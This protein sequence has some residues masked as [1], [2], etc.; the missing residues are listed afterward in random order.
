M[1]ALD[2]IGSRLQQ[3]L[4][5][6]FRRREAD[7]PPPPGDW[8]TAPDL[9]PPALDANRSERQDSPPQLQP[10][11][12]VFGYTADRLER[13]DLSGSGNGAGRAN[14]VEDAVRR[15]VEGLNS[16]GDQVAIAL[17]AGGN[18]LVPWRG[19][20]VGG[21][22]QYGYDIT[23]AQRGDA[24][25]PGADDDQTRYEVTFGKNLMGGVMAAM[26]EAPVR[27]GYEVNLRSADQVTMTFQTREE[28]V[29]AVTILQHV[30]AAETARDAGRAATPGPSLD[31]PA[32][33][34]LPENGSGSLPAGLPNPAEPAARM[35]EPSRADLEFLTSHITGFTTRL[36][37]QDRAKV[38]AELGNLGLEQRFD[39][40][41]QITR[42]VTLPQG[43]E[44]GRVTYTV[45]GELAPSTREKLKTG[46]G[47]WSVQNIVENGRVRAEVSI[48]YPIDV[49]QLGSTSPSG[50]PVP[51]TELIS[52][53]R[54]GRPDEIA[55]KITAERMDQPVIDLSRTDFRRLELNATLADPRDNARPVLDRIFDGNL[56]GAVA[57]SNG[58]LMITR[59][60]EDVARSG[61]NQQHELGFSEKGL[62]ASVS[63]IA[64]IG[65]DDV[66]NRQRVELRPEQ[67]P[68]ERPAPGGSA[69]EQLVVVPR[70]GLNV[71]EAPSAEAE[72]K[73]VLYHGTFVEATGGRETDAHGREWVEVKGRGTDGGEVQGWVAAEHVRTHAEGAMGPA[74]RV[75]PKLEE[76]GYRAVTVRPGD[77]VWQIAR[78]GG[79]DFGATMR[80]NQDHLIDQSLVFAGDKVYLPGTG[81]PPA[82]PEPPRDTAPPGGGP[83]NPSGGS[84]STPEAGSGTAPVPSPGPSTA[85]PNGSGSG[86]GNG[87]SAPSPSPGPAPSRPTPSDPPT[88]HGR[89]SLQEVLRE[90]Q[91]K[92]D[93][94]IVEVWRPDIQL[95]PVDLPDFVEGPIRGAAEEILDKDLKL[96]NVPRSEAEILDRL[97]TLELRDMLSIKDQAFARANEHYPWEGRETQFYGQN[98]GH[99]DA[100]RHAYWNALMTRR[101]GEGFAT[102][103]ATA[104]EAG[105]N[106]PGPREAMDL[107]NNELGRRIA[108]ENP[109]ASDAELQQLI[110]DAVERGEAVVIDAN[111]HL[112]WSHQ[113]AFLEHGTA[114]GQAPQPGVIDPNTSGS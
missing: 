106:N 23:V 109:E 38:S 98:D 3:G 75:N 6:V 60:T 97:D 47:P 16:D 32:A 37:P 92:D 63:L 104:H 77:N 61:V 94:E 31:N 1:N 100:F 85:P 18:V 70:D 13:G 44:P 84:P 114:D 105:Q 33:N 66:S 9:R 55:V 90:Y 87:P 71:R 57:E 102:E 26:P 17:T 28:A 103:Y 51:E 21:K 41:R 65:T 79:V 24:R 93:E 96:E 72:K 108:V 95:G 29:R 82:E 25:T 11:T 86:S 8:Q 52:G 30:A 58:A 14:P 48:S 80:L 59:T 22:V 91:V 20:P 62:E 5:Q 15:G 69:G 83:S 112:A 27:A 111:G 99:N 56:R 107:Y 39:A 110:K 34:P 73:G 68:V 81:K 10:A 46:I 64:N 40:N 78:D 42:T 74:G 54:L 101:F 113:V 7:P 89:P 67:E 50:K 12:A 43:D 53:A 4:E 35:L 76:Q 19:V 49:A 45:S 2:L 88:N 36:G